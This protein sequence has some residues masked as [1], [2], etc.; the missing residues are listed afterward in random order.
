MEIVCTL[1]NLDMYSIVSS[2][3]DGIVLG[4]PYSF[5]ANHTFTEDEIGKM[6]SICHKDDKKVFLLINLVMHEE[7]KEEVRKYIGKYKDEDVYYIFQDLGVLNILK[8]FG[9]VNRGIY[10]P[11]TMITNYE[12]LLAY[13]NLG[14]DAVGL[15]NEIPLEDIKL[16]SNKSKNVFYLGFGYHPIFQ[17]YRKV[18]S[19]YKEH[20]DLEYKLNSLSIKELNKDDRFP[21]LEN[22]YGS[23]IFRGG[24][25][26]ILESLEKVEGIK[27]LLI[28]G[29][30]LDEEIQRKVISIYSDVINNFITK[31]QG[32]EMMNELSLKY[33]NKFMY[34][35]SVYNPEDF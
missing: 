19:L 26:S 2:K 24:V 29:I 16:C 1:N 9:I 28:D 32:I 15:S 4:T 25:I 3:V 21:L 7:Y 18:A 34:E 23:V 11:L 14:L 12:D 27:Y 10:N 22:K 35:D 17:T 6:I 33:S 5:Y 30:F 8:E 31:K 13:D 20:S